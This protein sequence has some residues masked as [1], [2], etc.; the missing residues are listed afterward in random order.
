MTAA[1]SAKSSACSRTGASIRNT[2]DLPEKW[3]ARLQR[4]EGL[5]AKRS[6]WS[7]D[8]G[9]VEALGFTTA[10]EEV[11]RLLRGANI[12][13]TSQGSLRVA[14]RVVRGSTEV[15]NRLTDGRV[16][17]ARIIGG[18]QE[19]PLRMAAIREI[20]T[21][22]CLPNEPLCATCPLTQW[23]RFAEAGGQ[24]RLW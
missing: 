7:E 8:D 6:V 15:R 5:T 11:F 12:M 3:A 13:L 20:S 17:L 10:E 22:H 23:C 2:S 21:T 24:Q 14:M 1:R 9:L 18:G 19:A 4:L 16:N